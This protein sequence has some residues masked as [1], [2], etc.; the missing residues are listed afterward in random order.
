MIG[1]KKRITM[2]GNPSNTNGK[3]FWLIPLL[4]AGFCFWQGFSG[5]GQ[6]VT[7]SVAQ[8]QQPV[9]KTTPIRELQTGMR[10]IGENPELADQ[11]IEP[12]QIADPSGWRNVRLEMTK[13]DGSLLKITL[14]RPVEWLDFQ[15]AEVGSI[16]EL[17]LPELGAAGPAQVLAIEPCPDIEPGNRPL[18]T[19]T[20]EHTAA[21]EID[22]EIENEA[23]PIGTTDNHPFW[24]EDRQEFV[25]A[26][27]LKI[28]ETLRLADGRT[29]CLTSITPR[30]GPQTVYNLEVSGEHVYHV[31]NTGVLVHNSYSNRAFSGATEDSA[32][33]WDR[34]FGKVKNKNGWRTPD[35]KFASPL[36][37]GKPGQAAVDEVSKAINARK[38][39]R[40]VGEE[41]SVRNSGG[42]LRRYDLV[43]ESPSGRLIGIE[44][45]S[46]TATRNAAQRTFDM[47][48]NN[49]DGGLN[50]VGQYSHLGEIRRAL[51]ITVP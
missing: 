35:G 50:A 48:L 49:L 31:G 51:L 29:T 20:F 42:Q 8:P 45:K 28:G 44:V 12:L 39:W 3:W 2:R 22:L 38:G 24:S 5:E 43:A 30:A 46:G 7:P 33:G 15:E 17:D 1:T 14:L 19:G 13:A 4:L 34:I 16:I 32:R 6:A 25:E 26:G 9:L 11:Q 37:G 41:V 27:E 10:V 18:I 47:G 23:A 36:G 40:V 21:N